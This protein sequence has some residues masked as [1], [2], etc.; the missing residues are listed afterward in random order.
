MHT[1]YV[2][3]GTVLDKGGTIDTTNLVAFADFARAA[4][5]GEKRFVV[6]HSEIFPG[7]FASTTETADHLITALQLRRTAVLE[8]GPLGMQKLS[9]V[10]KGGLVVWGFAGNT[11]PDHIDHLHAYED[12]LRLLLSG[13]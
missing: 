13:P 12:F 11:A 4:V 3:E 2:Q 9:K 6:T 7:T 8:W 1:S 5:R 10:E